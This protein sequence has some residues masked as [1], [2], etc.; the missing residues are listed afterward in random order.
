[1]TAQLKLPGSGALDLDLTGATHRLEL[2]D[3]RPFVH[4]TNTICPVAYGH[5]SSSSSG[6]APAE[7]GIVLTGS[8]AG[9]GTTSKVR[10]EPVT[11][12]VDEAEVEQ[13]AAQTRVR[14]G[15]AQP[16]EEQIM[17]HNATHLPFRDWCAPCIAGKASDWPRSRITHSPTAIP[18]CQLD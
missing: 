14:K 8:R 4:D 5:S 10:S 18:M 12:T 7:G 13:D 16:T 17:K 15:P 11:L 1:M 9:A 6:A 2:M 3:P